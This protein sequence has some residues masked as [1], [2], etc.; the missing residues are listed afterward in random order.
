MAQDTKDNVFFVVD[1]PDIAASA[2]LLATSIY[3]H[4][5]DGV[6]QIA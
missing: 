5:K 1:G 6:T 2:A 4:N 3:D